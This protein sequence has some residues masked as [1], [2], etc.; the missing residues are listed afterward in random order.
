[1]QVS[2][3]I[4]DRPELRIINAEF[5]LSSDTPEYMSPE[6]ALT[7]GLDVDTRADVYSLGVILYEMLTDVLPSI[8]SNC[9]RRAWRRWRG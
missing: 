8:P 2:F 3:A 1:M 4:N 6:Q 5:G 7:S 9:A